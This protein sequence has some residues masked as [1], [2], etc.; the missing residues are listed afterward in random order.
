[1]QLPWAVPA[2]R[3]A[4]YLISG[5]RY[6]IRGLIPNNDPASEE[7]QMAYILIVDDAFDSVSALTEELK[8]EHEIAVAVDGKEALKAVLARTPDVIV[9]DLYMPEMDGIGFLEIIRS[10]LRLKSL[11]VIV[12]TGIQD[13]PIIERAKTLEVEA[14]LLKGR[15][16]PAEAARHIKRVLQKIEK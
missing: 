1:M 16:P 2:A 14:V 6:Y 9:L 8:A 4:L 13:S 15:T 12:L 11:P 5:L 7:V 10:Y 3:L